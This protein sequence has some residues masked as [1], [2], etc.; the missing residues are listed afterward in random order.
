MKNYLEILL[1]CWRKYDYFKAAAV[2][3]IAI[4]LYL[5][6]DRG[7]KT[8]AAVAVV[9]VVSVVATIISHRLIGD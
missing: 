4:H 5:L 3:L 6:V 2:G 7:I 1:E 8:A 9:C